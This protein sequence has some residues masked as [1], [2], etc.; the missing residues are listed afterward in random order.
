[1]HSEAWVTVQVVKSLRDI[2]C[3]RQGGDIPLL[4]SIARQLCPLINTDAQIFK[5]ILQANSTAH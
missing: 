1:M 5:L 2:L 3:H 4:C